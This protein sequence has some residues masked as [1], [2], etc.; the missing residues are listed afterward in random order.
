[1]Q[2]PPQFRR[3]RSEK[4]TLSVKS[5]V[6]VVQTQQGMFIVSLI[7]LVSIIGMVGNEILKKI[8]PDDDQ[9]ILV[10]CI[11]CIAAILIS[12]SRRQQIFAYLTARRMAK[13]EQRMQARRLRDKEQSQP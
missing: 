11:V 1:M 2:P 8:L 3:Q 5:A 4:L 6:T 13:F 9:A 12:L 7:L 10:T